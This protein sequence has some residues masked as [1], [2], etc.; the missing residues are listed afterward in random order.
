MSNC[1]S[2]SQAP[3]G[4]GRRE[5]GALGRHWIVYNRPGARQHAHAGYLMGLGLQR[6]LLVLANTDLY[7]RASV[8]S[9]EDTTWRPTTG[10]L[11]L[12]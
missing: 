5:E 1:V 10:S 8:A 2:T 12:C 4:C 11:G 3:P 7:R 6:H 9:N